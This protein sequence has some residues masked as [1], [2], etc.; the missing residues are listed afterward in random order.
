LSWA[1]TNLNQE[2]SVQTEGKRAE[3]SN[4]VYVPDEVK[5]DEKIISTDNQSA[6]TADGSSVKS[7]VVDDVSDIDVNNESLQIKTDTETTSPPA[8]EKKVAEIFPDKRDTN[9]EELPLELPEIEAE[10][11]STEQEFKM[12]SRRLALKLKLS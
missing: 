10:R 6:P 7:T 1:G 8:S 3:L 11:D 12:L 9:I 2:K 5:I 4:D